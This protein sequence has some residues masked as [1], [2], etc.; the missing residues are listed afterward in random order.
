MSAR[1][2]EAGEITCPRCDGE[3]SGHCRRCGGEG[4]VLF[5]ALRSGIKTKS[6]EVAA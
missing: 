1:A 3:N 6:A 2:P 4:V 5:S